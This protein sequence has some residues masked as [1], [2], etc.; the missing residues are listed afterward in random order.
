MAVTSRLRQLLNSEKA[1]LVV[2]LP[3]N[4]TELAEGAVAGG[5]DSILVQLN[6]EH[7]VT[8]SYTGGLDLE[9]AQIR[10]MCQSSKVP[11][12]LHIGTQGRLSKEDWIKA[13]Q[14]GL[15]YIATSILTIPPYML[16]DDSV[17]KML[18]VPTGLTLEH[19]RSLGTFEH[20]VA[21]SLE[22]LSQVQPDPQL[23]FS[24]VDFL[25]LETVL[26]LSGVPVL[27]RASQDLEQE[28]VALMISKGCSGL[29][30]D[31]AFTGSTPEHFRTVVSFFSS[32]ISNSRKKSKFIGYSPWG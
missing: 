29:V 9:T 26:R 28:D 15:D 20:V 10:V 7:P 25:N 27:F 19:Y 21:I 13:T 11:V 5:A 31:P 24:I 12:G 16:A 8:H 23:R 18:Y 1:V 32:A 30:L 14:L 3:S 4:S 6:N 22:A 17:E 2:E